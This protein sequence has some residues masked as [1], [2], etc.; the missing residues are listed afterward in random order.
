MDFMKN[1]IANR[2]KKNMEKM[3]MGDDGPEDNKMQTGLAPERGED[4]AEVG[5]DGMLAMAANEDADVEDDDMGDMGDSRMAR[6]IR[7]ESN[8]EAEEGKPKMDKDQLEMLMGLL[9][10]DAIG[11]PGLPG[12]IAAGL[13][14][15]IDK[16][17]MKNGIEND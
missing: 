3:A 12:K 17:K 10:E 15:A 11:K 5:K 9:N 13:K 14:A 16:L 8:M 2:R 4:P 6:G 1:A 7:V